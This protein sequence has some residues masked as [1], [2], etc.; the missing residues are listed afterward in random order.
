MLGTPY[1]QLPAIEIRVFFELASLRVHALPYV[2]K[3]LRTQS[4]CDHEVTNKREKLLLTFSSN[5]ESRK[6]RH[7][8]L[9]LTITLAMQMQIH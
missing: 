9:G 2:A 5:P 8:P 3:T 1:E 7:A 6:P 4:T